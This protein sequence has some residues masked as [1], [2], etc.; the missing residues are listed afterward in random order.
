M[1]CEGVEV[2]SEN[3]EVTDLLIDQ[4]EESRSQKGPVRPTG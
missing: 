3:L 4:G 2:Q 1:I